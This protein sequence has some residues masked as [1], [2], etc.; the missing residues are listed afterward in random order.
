MLSNLLL[1]AGPSFGLTR[2]SS[3][4]RIEV[5]PS[6]PVGKLHQK[7]VVCICVEEPGKV[8]PGTE[9]AGVAIVLALF[10][11]DCVERRAGLELPAKNRIQP[12]RLEVEVGVVERKGR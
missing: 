3:R 10:G 2:G 5:S 8:A 9:F 6:Q 1:G 11:P 4:P 12:E 7:H